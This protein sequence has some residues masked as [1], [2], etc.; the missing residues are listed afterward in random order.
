MAISNELHKS[1]SDRF[2]DQYLNPETRSSGV[3]NARVMR[4]NREQTLTSRPS[5]D[6]RRKRMRP[7][8]KGAYEEG[9]PIETPQTE[10]LNKRYYQEDQGLINKSIN[11]VPKITASIIVPS[12]LVRGKG[13]L[14]GFI[15]W[16]VMLL[17]APWQALFV[18]LGFSFMGMASQSEESWTTWFAEKAVQVTSWVSGFEYPDLMAFGTGSFLFAGILGLFSIIF[19]A[20]L[21]LFLRL[22]PL[23]GKGAGTKHGTF[24]LALLLS[25]VP[26]GSLLWIWSVVRHPK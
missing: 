10:K 3:Q 25:P 11:A 6:G 24:M 2:N 12:F 22:H 21:A 18:M 8:Y 26:F 14:F 19:F 1:T 15:C 16:G 9:E 20:S 7:R 4:G 23:N 5:E 13:A 17:I